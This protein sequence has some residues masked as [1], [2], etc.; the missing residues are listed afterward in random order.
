[1]PRVALVECWVRWLRDEHHPL[2]TA[3]ALEMNPFLVAA[4]V[5]R[6]DERPFVLAVEA[7]ATQLLVVLH[8]DVTLG[9]RPRSL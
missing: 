5:A 3:Q 9:F 2:P 8:H 7:V 4:A 1:M 6:A